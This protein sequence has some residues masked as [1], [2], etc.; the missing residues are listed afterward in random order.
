VLDRSPDVKFVIGHFGGGI[1]AVKERLVA[2]GYRFGTLKRLFEDYFDRPYFDLTGFEGGV[3][4]LRCAL[5]GIRPECLVF[6]SDY[7]QDFTGVNTDTGKGMRALRDYIETIRGLELK[8][9]LKDAILGGT[10]ACVLKLE[11]KT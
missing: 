10:A 9:E 2:K 5:L 1:S 4:A 6:A 7:P 11:R 3:A 8:E